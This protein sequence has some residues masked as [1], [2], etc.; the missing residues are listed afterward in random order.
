MITEAAVPFSIDE[1]KRWNSPVQAEFLF[2]VAIGILEIHCRGVFHNNLNSLQWLQV[3]NGRAQICNFGL[4]DDNPSCLKDRDACHGLFECAEEEFYRLQ[5]P[6]PNQDPGKGAKLLLVQFTFEEYIKEVLQHE[7]NTKR[8]E[9]APSP[10]RDLGLKIE[11]EAQKCDFPLDLYRHLLHSKEL[12]G[13]TGGP[14]DVGDVLAQLTVGLDAE[15]KER[16]KAAVNEQVAG[17]GSLT[18]AFFAHLE[19]K[20]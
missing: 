1:F 8:D 7:K 2:S 16:F 3:R 4:L 20:S 17:H 13:S 19:A 18:P 12:W 11:E 6:C 14:L 10:L 15:E 5:R 9:S